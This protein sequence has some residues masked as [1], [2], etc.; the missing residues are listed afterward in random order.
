M[1]KAVL[2]VLCVGFCFSSALTWAKRIPGPLS[3]TSMQF[4]ILAGS[5]CKPNSVAGMKKLKNRVHKYTK[6]LGFCFIKIN[7]K[8]KVACTI[9]FSLFT[10]AIFTIKILLVESEC[11]IQMFIHTF[12]ITP[13][14]MFLQI[15][16]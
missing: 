10:T 7:I 13:S 16:G 12:S 2:H 11:Y 9:I 8:Q 6:Q 5:C 15:E 1:W 14:E 4:C 3:I